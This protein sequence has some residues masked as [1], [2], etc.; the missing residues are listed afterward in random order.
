[1]ALACRPDPSCI[2]VGRSGE[3]QSLEAFGARRRKKRK[4]GRQKARRLFLRPVQPVGNVAILQLIAHDLLVRW[5][6]PFPVPGKNGLQ[7]W[8]KGRP[9]RLPGQRLQGC[10][11]REVFSVLAAY[12]YQGGR[13]KEEDEEDQEGFTVGSTS[14][15]SYHFLSY[16]CVSLL[17]VPYRIYQEH[18]ITMVQ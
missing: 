13:G 5:S 6:G 8:G 1:M 9:T 14:I 15:I 11:L 3:W 4:N 2:G 18:P 10:G 12:V 16:Y 17:L 7:V